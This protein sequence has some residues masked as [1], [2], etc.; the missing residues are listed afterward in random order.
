M[1]EAVIVAMGRSAI[2]KAPKGT[3]KH[4][5]PE[6]LASQV[7]K[8]V[9]AKLPGLPK[10]EIDDVI[11]G[12]AF[13]E[14]EQGLNLGR[15]VALEANLGVEVPGQ[16]IN[17]FCSSGLQAIVA[18]S[19]SI[20]TGQ[21]DIIIAGGVESM[22]QIPMGGNIQTPNPTLADE[23]PHVYDPMGITAE[24]VAKT[25]KVTRQR[26]DEFALLSHQR[27]AAAQKSGKFAEEIIPIKADIDEQDV[28]GR[29][30]SKKII[31]DQDEG[32][33]PNTSM[34]ALSKLRTNFKLNG[35]VTAGNSSQT[36]DGA[37]FVVMMSNEK[38]KELGC[39]PLA[40]LIGYTVAGVPPEVMGIGPMYAIPKALKRC[41]LTLA[42]IDLFELNEAFASQAVVCIDSLGLDREK[43]N[44]NGGAIALGHPLGCTGAAL[45]VKLLYEMRRRGYKQGIVSMCIGGGMGAA[46]V[47]KLL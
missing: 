15:I 22:S 25:Y 20:E 30:I 9:L 32:I 33:R 3:L 26:Q 23:C 19:N 37:A 47:Y 7:L 11:I 39:T 16:T 18:A 24:N 28:D 14:A 36:S 1:T 38:A 21:A 10:N 8:G 44:V 5:R 13:P 6:D 29:M 46:G 27:A 42:D 41:G 43:V 2:G 12:C 45:T 17:R 40:K 4:T 35:C 31:F 34:E